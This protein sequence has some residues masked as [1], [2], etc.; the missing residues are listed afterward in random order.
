GEEALALVEAGID[1]EVVPGVTAGIGA[2]AYA[3]IPITHR[4]LASNVGLVTGHESPE[5]Q[6][7]ALDWQ[8]L[9]NWNGTLAFYMGVANLRHICRQLTSH[10]LDEDTPA[11]LIR[12]GTTP[13][14]EVLTGVVGDIA[15]LADAADFKPPALIVIGQVVA[16]REKLNWF[17]RRALFGQRIVVTRSRRQASRLSHRLERLGAEVIEVPAIRIEPPEDTAALRKAIDVRASF[18]WII[19][20]SANAVDAFF[21]ALADAALDSRA[22]ASNKIC[23]IGPATA[24][25]LA[26]FGICP[27]AQ[28]AKYTGEAV[29]ETLAALQDLS[30]MGILCPRAD[31]APADLPKALAARGA[32]VRNV[33][34]YRTVAETADS[35]RVAE[36]LDGDE[37]DWITFTSSSTVK[38]FFAMVGP[39]RLSA[40]SVRLASI[41]PVTSATIREAGLLPAVEAEEHTIPGLVDAIVGQQIFEKE[42]L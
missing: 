22:L 14:Q 32:R 28:P 23:T 13:R 1:F 29:V 8:A 42:S 35:G 18:D 33:V 10:G 24:E 2:A 34:A 41:G 27:D 4:G 38:N 17:E 31:I 36:L 6:G 26:G 40:G 19:F 5:K 11:A 16:L 15:S 39:D 30:G 25:R 7:S 9:A 20:T 3:G 37:I 21:E 12:W